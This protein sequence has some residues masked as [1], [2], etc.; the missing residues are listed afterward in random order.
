MGRVPEQPAVDDAESA[1]TLVAR[2]PCFDRQRRVL[3]LE[4]VPPS[5][6]GRA[7]EHVRNLPVLDVALDRD[8]RL[9]LALADVRGQELLP[10]LV[11][12]AL[13]SVPAGT[14]VVSEVVA[15]AAALR[16]VA[17]VGTV[18]DRADEVSGATGLAQS[19]G[20][21]LGDE[22]Q[23]RVLGPAQ[24]SREQLAALLR[25]G[26][27]PD[28]VVVAVPQRSVFAGAPVTSSRRA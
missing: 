19:L 17:R 22:N 2:P 27:T 21:A 3:E 10:N 25:T 28:E 13:G 9:P 1:V 15:P 7:H 16:D 6:L 8:L 23:L 20:A 24:V 12:E 14:A 11:V 5:T 4:R 18:S 26:E